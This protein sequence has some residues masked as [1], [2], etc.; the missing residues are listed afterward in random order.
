MGKSQTAVRKFDRDRFSTMATWN[1]RGRQIKASAATTVIEIH[2]GWK[3]VDAKIAGSCGLAAACRAGT[4]GP[5][6]MAKMTKQPTARF[7]ASVIGDA[8]AIA[9]INS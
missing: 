8:K 2:S 1:C 9:T 6:N 4:E 5:S 3:C 7:A